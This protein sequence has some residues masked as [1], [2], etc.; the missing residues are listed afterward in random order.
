MLSAPP[1]T[2]EMTFELCCPEFEYPVV[3]VFP[4]MAPL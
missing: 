4:G 1:L 2:L 3:H